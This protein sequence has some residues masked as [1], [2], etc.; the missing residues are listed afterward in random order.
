MSEQL[1]LCPA[2]KKHNI[3]QTTTRWTHTHTCR[4]SHGQMVPNDSRCSRAYSN[5]V[6]QG[7]YCQAIWP[8]AND[9]GTS[10]DSL[11]QRSVPTTLL[12]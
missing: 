3:H 4:Y 11:Q 9:E 6:P 2:R 8:N 10:V 1:H 5:C 7:T 12:Q